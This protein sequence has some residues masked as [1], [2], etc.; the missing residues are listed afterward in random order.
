MNVTKISEKMAMNSKENKEKSM[1]EGLMAE[2]E[3][4]YDVVIISK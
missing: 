4:K 1:Q 2:G 3:A